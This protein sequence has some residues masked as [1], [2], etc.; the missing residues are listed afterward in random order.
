MRRKTR[1]PCMQNPGVF[2]VV[3]MRY[4]RSLFRKSIPVQVHAMPEPDI[5]GLVI[6][7]FWRVSLCEFP[8]AE[9]ASASSV[10]THEA[11]G[12]G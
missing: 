9:T 1:I 7:V 6:S 4:L 10:L 8:T 3:E 5:N 11:D 2:K 12:Q